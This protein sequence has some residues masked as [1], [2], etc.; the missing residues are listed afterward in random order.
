MTKL[1]DDDAVG[2]TVAVTRVFL[3][4]LLVD[5]VVVCPV[6]VVSVTVDDVGCG[7]CVVVGSVTSSVQTYVAYTPHKCSISFLQGFFVFRLLHRMFFLFPPDDDVVGIF[8]V[9]IGVLLI[10]LL[11]DSVGV[12]RVVVVSGTVDDIG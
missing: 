4:V 10:V 12:G 2:V 3:I 7:D 11:V 5:A 6:V 1:P 9:V 8:V